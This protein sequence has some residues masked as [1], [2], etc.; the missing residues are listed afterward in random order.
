MIGYEP[1][2]IAILVRAKERG[3][4]ADFKNI[5]VMGTPPRVC[6]KKLIKTP[7]PAHKRKD[8]MFVTDTFV[9]PAVNMSKCNKCKECLAFCPASAVRLNAA[10]TIVVNYNTCIFCY[11]C[12]SACKTQAFFIR[13][14]LKNKVIRLMRFMLGF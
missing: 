11:Y 14:S 8:G 3:L 12:L 2:E 10:G 6:F 7:L 13:S 1:E 5:E 4:L 9:Y